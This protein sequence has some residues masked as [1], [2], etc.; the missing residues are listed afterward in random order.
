M[1]MATSSM[2]PIEGVLH[3]PQ[4]SRTRDSPSDLLHVLSRSFVVGRVL[5]PLQKCSQCIL[6][7]QVTEQ[8]CSR[9]RDA[10]CMCV[11]PRH[12]KRKESRNPDMYWGSQNTSPL[13]PVGGRYFKMMTTVR[14]FKE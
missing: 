11:H 4:S 2:Q 5:T 7:P 1:N 14:P 3:L 9:F 12:Q 8:S 6:Q 13:I 10:N